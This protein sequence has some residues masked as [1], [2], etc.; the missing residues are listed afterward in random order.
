MEG[1]GERKRKKIIWV[2]VKSEAV[3]IQRNS[4][5]W[6]QLK[7][8]WVI[9]PQLPGNKNGLSSNF[10]I[11]GKCLTGRSQPRTLLL[12]KA[13]GPE[14]MHKLS[15]EQVWK[16][17]LIKCHSLLL[18]L[19]YRCGGYFFLYRCRFLTLCP[20]GGLHILNLKVLLTTL[21]TEHGW[22]EDLRLVGFGHKDH[23]TAVYLAFWEC[24]VS[25]LS[26]PEP[27]HN[28][29]WSWRDIPKRD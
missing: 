27:S 14:N 25:R 3:D 22:S 7:R 17:C 28:L 5:W 6:T 2:L 26:H 16:G 1:L 13:R 18:F 19:M 21:M 29:E 15:S 4:H 9:Y 8:R 24:F 23:R 11:S 12:L 10:Q 20:W